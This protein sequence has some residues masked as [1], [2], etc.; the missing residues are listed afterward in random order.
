MK[1][2]FREGKLLGQSFSNTTAILHLKT[3]ELPVSM[4]TEIAW[5]GPMSYISM[6]CGTKASYEASLAA[7]L[8]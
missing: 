2:H 6:F 5:Y 4:K 3:A 7:Q 1:I 8:Y